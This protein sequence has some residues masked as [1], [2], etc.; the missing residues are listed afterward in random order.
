MMGN[1]YDPFFTTKPVGQGSGLGLSICLG[2][3]ERHD[4]MLEL[5][6]R[7]N[8]GVRASISLLS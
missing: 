8:G 3:V 5:I 7:R 6:N 1:I 2:I 4:G